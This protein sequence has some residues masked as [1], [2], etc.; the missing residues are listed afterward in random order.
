MPSLVQLSLK[1]TM[2][3]S[4]YT[5]NM[6]SGDLMDTLIALSLSAQQSGRFDMSCVGKCCPTDEQQLC[7]CV[8]NSV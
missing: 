7:H 8:C 2:I 1:K 6:L 5:A 3:S 4:S